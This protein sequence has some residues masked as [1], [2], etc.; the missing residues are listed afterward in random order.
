MSEA[1]H[2]LPQTDRLL[3]RIETL[4]SP[5]VQL[6][7]WPGSGKMALLEALIARHGARAVPLPLA[8]V[9]SR[10]ALEEALESAH[11]VGVR[12]LVATGGPAGGRLT[13]AE[14]WLRP[15]QRTRARTPSTLPR[16]CP[17]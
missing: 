1:A 15:G 9:A 17:S 7:G 5:L 10:E 2:L 6:W 11:E 3:S 4:E 14:H 8:A 16:R 13:E 12:W